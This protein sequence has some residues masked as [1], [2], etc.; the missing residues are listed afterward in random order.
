VGL[1]ASPDA[2]ARGKIL[3]S[4]PGVE[5]QSP[6]RPACSQTLYCLSY[7]AHPRHYKYMEKAVEFT[8]I[9]SLKLPV[10][11][12]SYCIFQTTSFM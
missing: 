7:P 11:A 8:Y 1:R 9:A 10:E 6:G 5:P 2:E 4:P 12:T 3:S